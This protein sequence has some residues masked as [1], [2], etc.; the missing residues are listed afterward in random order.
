MSFSTFFAPKK[1]PL[2]LLAFWVFGAAADPQETAK[3]LAAR[4][5]A[6]V[7]ELKNLQSAGNL[8][9][10]AALLLIQKEMSPIID[11]DKL[12]SQA[13]G[14]YWRRAKE[15]EKAE[16]AAAFQTL[17]EATYA[18]ILAQYSDQSVKILSSKLREDGKTEVAVEISGGQRTV[19]VDYIFH[20]LESGEMRIID[21]KVEGVSLLSNYRRQFAGIIKKAGTAGLAAALKKLAAKK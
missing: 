11:F 1:W 7:R 21:I 9:A 20:E 12:A 10:E 15:T 16:I 8:S 6:V 14:K 17:M 3:E 13:T 18:K 19:N 5:D 2:F 4:K